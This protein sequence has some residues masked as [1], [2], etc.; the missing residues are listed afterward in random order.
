MRRPTSCATRLLAASLGLTSAC[1]GW[2]PPSGEAPVTAWPTL[3]I[4]E[5]G[6]GWRVHAGEHVS[7]DSGL[8][9]RAGAGWT[10]LVEDEVPFLSRPSQVGLRH[11]DSDLT[12]IFDHDP[13]LEG[14]LARLTDTVREG[15]RSALLLGEVARTHTLEF[16]GTTIDVEVMPGT[17]GYEYVLALL[18]RRGSVTL[19]GRYPVGE[20][21]GA[22]DSIREAL[23]GV[24]LLTDA[25]LEQLR[26]TLVQGPDADNEISDNWV[27]RRGVYRNFEH[28][29]EWTD[30]SRSWSIEP[31]DEPDQVGLAIADRRALYGL[32]SIHVGSTVSSLDAG[33]WH[34]AMLARLDDAPEFLEPRRSVALGHI[35]GLVDRV[36]YE[37]D[38]QSVVTLLLTYRHR[39]EGVTWVVTGAEARALSERERVDAVVEGLR[40]GIGLEREQVDAERHV[41]TLAGYAF[42]PPPGPSS[43]TRKLELGAWSSERRW[44]VEGGSVV[45][46]VVHWQ[47]DANA[48]APALAELATDVQSRA[49]LLERPPTKTEAIELAGAPG[50]HR[51]WASKRS[52]DDLVIVNRDRTLYALHVRADGA[53]L[54]KRCLAGFSFVD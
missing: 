17:D 47:G 37:F 51:T 44:A 18:A 13:W 3:E 23:A 33:G 36:R 30:P 28:D 39:N 53:A 27:V 29:V 50:H 34:A 48:L 26:T 54:L 7:V 11:A 15:L 9:V 42:A 46:T 19:L 14:D 49:G 24:E 2:I 21:D 32:L 1:T 43:T 12:L 10:L 52:R 16:A 5:T 25:E 4:D 40:V 6:P 38:G 20:R 8:R 22:E 35:P 41:D 45:V 31:R